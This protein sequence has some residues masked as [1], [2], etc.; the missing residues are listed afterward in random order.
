MASF[1]PLIFTCVHCSLIALAAFTRNHSVRIC[2]HFF[3][4]HRSF[5]SLTSSS[6]SSSWLTLS[7]PFTVFHLHWPY[8]HAVSSIFTH[9]QNK[10]HSCTS[11][12]AFMSINLATLFTWLSSTSLSSLIMGVI[13]SIHR[14]QLVALTYNTSR[15]PL[16]AVRIVI[17]CVY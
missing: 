6:C 8:P 5:G 7:L 11:F 13:V 17:R 10:F 14:I 9:S 2:F 15:H 1:L 3:H 12:T 16:T 4:L